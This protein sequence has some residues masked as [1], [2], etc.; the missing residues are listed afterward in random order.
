MDTQTPRT[1][2]PSAPSASRRRLRPL[3]LLA[4]AATAALTLTAG[5]TTP[6]N[7]APQR[8]QAAADDGKTSS[9]SPWRR[10]STR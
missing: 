3:R 8:A 7:P 1:T 6:L 5:L 4:A 10:A 9:P 2:K